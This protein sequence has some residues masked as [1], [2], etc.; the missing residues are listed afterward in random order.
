MERKISRKK[1]I[2]DSF[3]L[4]AGGTMLLSGFLFKEK[5]IV[6]TVNGPLEAE[7][8]GFVLTHEHI[9]ADFIGAEKYSK[10]RYS[11]A[12]VVEVALPFLKDAKAKGVNTF[13][14]FFQNNFSIR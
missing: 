10:S 9:M 6:M 8:M 4:G 3:L 2:A 1:F 7:R 5:E 13:I 12:E 11:V 14:D